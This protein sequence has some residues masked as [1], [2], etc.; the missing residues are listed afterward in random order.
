MYTHVERQ[1]DMYPLQHAY[2]LNNTRTHTIAI[3]I[4][5]QVVGESVTVGII[6]PFY[7]VGYGISVRV[8]V[9]KIS[10]AVA[11]RIVCALHS[12]RNPILV[13]ICVSVVCQPVSI[14]I[15]AALD[16]IG[17]SIV[18]ASLERMCGCAGV[19]ERN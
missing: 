12:I 7:G 14:E 3:R 5:I 15:A 18:V 4:V 17:Y 16:R 1:G 13:R 6:H 8:K 9:D 10:L 11:V 2:N 19:R